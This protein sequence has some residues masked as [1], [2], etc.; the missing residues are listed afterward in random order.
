M[1]AAKTSEEDRE[2]IN[3]LWKIGGWSQN[4]LGKRF[5]IT[6]TTVRMIVD[7]AYAERRRKAINSARKLRPPPSE[8][9]KRAK[10][11]PFVPSLAKV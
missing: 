9:A 7:P 1:M 6:A 2:E 10:P 11:A 4:K 3:R 8:L 5:H